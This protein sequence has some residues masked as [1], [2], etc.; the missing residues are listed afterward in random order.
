[1]QVCDRLDPGAGEVQ[2][3]E[4]RGRRDAK[5]RA[6]FRR[7]VDVPRGR[8][9]SSGNVKDVLSKDPGFK[10]IWDRFVED[11]HSVFFFLYCECKSARYRRAEKGFRF[12]MRCEVLLVRRVFFLR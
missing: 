8:E 4:L 10:G 7:D 3:P 6:A 11:S 5:V 1:M 9:W 12:N 2:V